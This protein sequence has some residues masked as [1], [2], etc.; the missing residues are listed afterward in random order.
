MAGKRDIKISVKLGKITDTIDKTKAH[1]IRTMRNVSFKN[2]SEGVSVVMKAEKKLHPL[3]NWTKDMF[4][5]K[6][7]MVLLL[8]VPE[9]IQSKITDYND[10]TPLKKT[11]VK[12]KSTKK[13][14]P[15]KKAPVKK[16]IVE[17]EKIKDDIEEEE[18]ELEF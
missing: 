7:D 17:K 6:E 12:K 8:E 15:A 2:K 13:K 1:D 16:K 18:L 9:V 11:P 3:K 4:N 10:S 5:E 14:Q